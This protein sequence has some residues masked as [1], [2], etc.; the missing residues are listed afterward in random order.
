[1][2]ELVVVDNVRDGCASLDEY[3]YAVHENV[4]DAATV[5]AL[6]TRL[7]DQAAAERD[8][9]VA[10]FSSGGHAS[11]DKRIGRPDPGAP[12]IFQEVK[13]LVNKGR[14]FLDL[15][16][17]PVV[18]EYAEHLFHGEPYNLASHNGVILRRGASEQVLHADQQ[19]I[20]LTLDRPVMF[21]MMVCLSDFD[22]DMGSTTVVPGSHRLPAPD[23]SRTVEEQVDARGLELVPLT[24]KAG[25]IMFWESRTWHRQGASVS[26][27]DRVSVG[28]A[29]A[30]HFVKP[31][32]FFPAV[33]HD[34]VYE[35][36]SD[37]DKDLLG[38]RVI[39]EYA[40]AI[41]PRN[42]HDTRTNTNVAY[43]F[44]P[45]LTTV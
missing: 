14:V 25:S 28:S 11:G 7:E 1:M 19:A 6:R 35:T 36:L 2:H 43:P 13:H 20:P 12:P 33:V 37:R 42:A 41:G 44:V 30:Q 29:W 39:R 9:G 27:R 31:Q 5:E 26:D 34:D 45:E 22:A 4:L 40:G 3:G 38:F 15:L 10:V 17:E 32:D 24:A 8:A 16:H 23:M 21:V 18:H